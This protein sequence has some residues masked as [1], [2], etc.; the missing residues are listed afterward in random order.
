M[1]VFTVTQ[2]HSWHKFKIT[3][4]YW[5]RPLFP[6]IRSAGRI[7]FSFFLPPAEYQGKEATASLERLNL[8]S[9]LKKPLKHVSK[10]L[11]E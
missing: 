9:E 6:G 10:T 2:C 3:F 5:Q 11:K 1:W 4:P 8:T 7:R